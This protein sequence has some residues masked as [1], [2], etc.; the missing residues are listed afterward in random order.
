MRKWLKINA[1]LLIVLIVLG[2]IFW[3]FFGQSE[4]D[5]REKML[6]SVKAKDPDFPDGNAVKLTHFSYFGT[7]HTREGIYYVAYLR[8]VLT[9]MLAP[10][11]I[12]YLE[13]FDHQLNWV[14]KQVCYEW[15]L[16]CDNGGVFLY[17]FAP[18]GTA[19]AGDSA[20][21]NYWDMSSGIEARRLV[22]KP[23]YG[24]YVPDE[25]IQLY[26]TGKP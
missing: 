12:S 9:G 3:S 26:W 13:F 1:L 22:S 17:G 8:A 4:L 7:V 10:R 23:S 21:G 24:S 15:P 6:V 14:D 2:V 19:G 18:A 25:Q 5:T 11:G 16:W 20:G